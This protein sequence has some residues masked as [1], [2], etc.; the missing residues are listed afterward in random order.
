MP[1]QENHCKRESTR[2]SILSEDS[3]YS[4]LTKIQINY[5]DYFTYEDSNKSY[6][7]K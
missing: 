3:Y 7:A 1:Y 4:I 6:S 2:Y 5:C